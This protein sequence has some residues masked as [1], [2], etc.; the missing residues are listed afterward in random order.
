MR[1]DLTFAE[2]VKLLANTN[3]NTAAS[4]DS[5]DGGQVVAGHGFEPWT[6]GL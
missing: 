4:E 6:S 2:A 1:E 5:E 3:K